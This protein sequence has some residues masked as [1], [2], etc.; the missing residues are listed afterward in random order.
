MCIPNRLVFVFFA[1][2]ATA[3]SAKSIYFVGNSLTDGVSYSNLE[4]LAEANGEQHDWGRHM[5]PGAPLEWNWNHPDDC[6]SQ[7]P[8]GCYQT[9]L[10][11]YSWDAVSLQPFD[12]QLNSDTEYA[13]NFINLA[14]AQNPDVQIFIYGRW[15]NAGSR[16]DFSEWFDKEYTGGWDG[17]NETRDY[18]E[19]LVQQ[20]RQAHSDLPPIKLMPISEVMYLLDQRMKAGQ[21]P[22]YSSVFEVYT[23]GWHMDNVGSFICGCTAYAI[24]YDKNPVGLTMAGYSLDNDLAGR[25]QQAVWDVVSVYEY[26][27]IEGVKVDDRIA[28]GARVDRARGDGANVL[29][30]L[31][32]RRIVGSRQSNPRGAS[33]TR[34]VYVAGS[35]KQ[36]SIRQAI[37]LAP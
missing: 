4:A 28:R 10:N 30:D 14:K 16:S 24:L 27:R 2:L 20:L 12:R 13:T 21:I 37:I 17:T 11:N 35:E 8:Y 26:G 1:A 7:N 36:Q 3:S 33:L 34:G 15:P 6:I 22:G 19:T 25:I 18:L 29:Y 32:G 5:I 23:D 9:A 31:R